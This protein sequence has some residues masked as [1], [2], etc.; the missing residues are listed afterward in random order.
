MNPLS[1][2]APL[3]GSSRAASSGEILLSA[4]WKSASSPSLRPR[5]KSDGANPAEDAGLSVVRGDDTRSDSGTVQPVIAVVVRLREV[6]EYGGRTMT[7]QMEDLGARMPGNSRAAAVRTNHEVAL[8]QTGLPRP[9][10]DVRATHA[11]RRVMVELA[12]HLAEP[13][14]G[15]RLLSCGHEGGVEHGPTRSVERLH[16][17][18]RLYGDPDRIGTV[19]ERGRP[20]RRG[21]RSSDERPEDPSGGAGAHRPA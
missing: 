10:S 7:G 4:P 18:P 6:P 1:W 13:E 21:P 14:L 11:P 17:V 2:T 9:A 16:T 3:C 8:H 20:D 19:V 15:T 5:K 12:N